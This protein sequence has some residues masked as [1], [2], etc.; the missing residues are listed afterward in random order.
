M[1]PLRIRIA[2]QLGLRIVAALASQ[3]L[4]GA[5][6]CVWAFRGVDLR[7]VEHPAEQV[8]LD[9][10]VKAHLIDGSTL[11]Y[12]EPVLASDGALRGPGRRFGLTLTDSTDVDVVP[13]DSVAAIEEFHTTVNEGLSWGVSGVSSIAV[14][15]FLTW[16]WVQFS[17]LRD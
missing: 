2:P 11:L 3:A 1:K 9:P 8:T 12:R 10:P 15:G 13:L 4:L 5:S 16:L 14:I 6:G 7:G 17:A